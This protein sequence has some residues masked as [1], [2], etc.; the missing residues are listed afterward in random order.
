M[1]HINRQNID[2]P[3]LY[4]QCVNQKQNVLLRAGLLLAQPTVMQDS[5]TYEQMGQ[6]MSLFN[7]PKP[8]LP[9]G[10]A[11][12]QDLVDLYESTL[13]RKRGAGRWAYDQIKAS[14]PRGL[15]PMCGQ[16]TVG[17]L[18]HYLP[19]ETFWTLA[20]TPDNLLP[21]CRD[22]NFVKRAIVPET[23]AMQSF[24]PYFDPA[25]DAQWL[26]AS[27]RRVG[28]ISAGFHVV[29]PPEWADQRRLRTRNHFTIFGL[30]KLY[31][32]H[33]AD[34]LVNMKHRLAKL[35]AKGGPDA[36][37]IHLAEEAASRQAVNLNSWQGALYQALSDD[38]GF[39]SGDFDLV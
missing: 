2:F 20:I 31:V 32:I 4:T 22:C 27:V 38:V 19:K 8:Q 5:Q 39:C 17:T 37:R 11:T 26:F 14:A 13:A 30:E 24:H 33:P 3:L 34:E 16:R 28:G 21:A 36:V 7:F 35:H 23:E 1:R 9:V 12:E 15:C 10:G 29:D 25:D 18:D 6:T